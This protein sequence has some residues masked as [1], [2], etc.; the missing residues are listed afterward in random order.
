MIGLDDWIKQMDYL[1]DFHRR[2]GGLID[3]C[4]ITQNAKLFGSL[5]QNL[6]YY[7][8]YYFVH[9]TILYRPTVNCFQ[10]TWAYLYDLTTIA[11]GLTVNFSTI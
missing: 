1:F 2:E 4:C 8:I 11:F 6:F 7:I 5:L 10:H 9:Y 3:I